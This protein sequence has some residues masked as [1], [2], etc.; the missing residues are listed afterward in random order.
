MENWRPRGDGAGVETVEEFR[1]CERLTRFA[2]RLLLLLARDELGTW[3][4]SCVRESETFLVLYGLFGVSW[5]CIMC[6]CVVIK[7]QTR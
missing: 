1:V 3:I 7:V 6:C 2:G 4:P 5:D